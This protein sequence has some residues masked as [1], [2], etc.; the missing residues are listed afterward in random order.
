MRLSYK[1]IVAFAVLLVVLAAYGLMTPQISHHY[2]IRVEKGVM[3][4]FITLA[5]A[6][7]LTQWVR[8]L[9]KVEPKPGNLP[10]PGL[11]VGSYT[12]FYSKGI[13]SRYYDLTVIK[14]VPLSEM[15]VKLTNIEADMK[16]TVVL[17]NDG[18]GTL[19]IVDVL[20]KANTVWGKMLLP[21]MKW[22][23]GAEI[24]GNFEKFK[25]VVE[26]S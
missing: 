2:E 13:V 11:P 22:R 9:E 18:H 23:L 20:A 6:D 19:L 24:D 8:G 26:A 7:N 14:A 3:P 10:F 1:V 21:Y 4:V 15:A 17:K 5:N 16:C 12:L 25:S